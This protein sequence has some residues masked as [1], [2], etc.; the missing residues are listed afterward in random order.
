MPCPGGCHVVG[1]SL[2][3]PGPFAEQM[4]GA[5]TISDPRVDGAA[6]PYFA[7]VGWRNGNTD[8]GVYG[9]QAVTGTRVSGSELTVDLETHRQ[10]AVAQL[11]PAD[12]PRALPV[13][14][15][16]TATPQVVA[17]L[18][19]DLKISTSDQL[20]VTVHPVATTESTP[21]FGPSALLI[22]ATSYIR[23]VALTNAATTVYIL[24]RGDTPPR[25]TNALAAHGISSP[26]RLADVRRALDQDAYALALNLYAVVTVLVILLALAG[27]AVNMAVQIPARRR[28]AAS[29]RVVGLR[30]RS[31]VTAVAA[32]LAAVL[33]T[34][35]V[36]GILAG[37]LSQYVVVRTLT[38]GYADA[39]FTPR[40]LPSLD[41][42]TVAVLLAVTFAVLLVV[43]VL[44]GNLTIHG[45]RT[46]TLRETAA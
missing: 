43:A 13:L 24:A 5:V 11:V 18:G 23:A 7:G 20:D 4:H 42:P 22:D 29:L 9:P 16:R 10:Q 38:L 17:R 1:L 33:G 37:A 40:V 41:V 28:D 8:P 45:A 2:G 32:E 19:G 36:A 12:A 27:L 26:L 34:A 44:L 46:A 31:I 35:A 15:G 21:Y 39:T 25:I 3:G 30:R 14:L 6:V